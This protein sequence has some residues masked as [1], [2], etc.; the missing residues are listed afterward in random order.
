LLGLAP[1]TSPAATIQLSDITGGQKFLNTNVGYLWEFTFGS[2]GTHALDV[3]FSLKLAPN[4]TADAVLSLYAVGTP[5]A[6][7]T[8]TLLASNATQSFTTKT[9]SLASYAFVT[10]TTYRLALT[11]TAATSSFTWYIKD[12]NDLNVQGNGQGI[13]LTSAPIIYDPATTTTTQLTSGGTI[14]PTTASTTDVPDATSTLPLAVLGLGAAL[15]ARR[16]KS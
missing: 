15:V 16:R 1:L 3:D 13:S 4:T 2:A 10:G 7:Q 5:G 12:P 11:S 6:V 9:F 14:A 8:S